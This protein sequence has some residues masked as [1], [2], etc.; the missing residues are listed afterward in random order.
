MHE[1]NIFITGVPNAIYIVGM[2]CT[3]HRLCRRFASVNND[4][5]NRLKKN[6][7]NDPFQSVTIDWFNAP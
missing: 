4:N 3:G 6:I 5:E 7:K 1:S 2:M